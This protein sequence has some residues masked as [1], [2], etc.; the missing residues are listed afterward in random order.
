MKR[1]GKQL[2]LAEGYELPELAKLQNEATVEEFMNK[3]S[4]AL[5]DDK[6]AFNDYIKAIG[7]QIFN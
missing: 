3:L 6:E 4:A 7:R 1:E 2:Q 5:T